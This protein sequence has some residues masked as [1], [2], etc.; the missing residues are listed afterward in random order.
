[1]LEWTP[2]PHIIYWVPVRSN[3]RCV[4]SISWW[5]QCT[6][7]GQTLELDFDVSLLLD[8]TS[9]TTT[10]LLIWK[11][12]WGNPP[13]SLTIVLH[14]LQSCIAKLSTGYSLSVTRASAWV[15]LWEP[16]FKLCQFIC[17]GQHDMAGLKVTLSNMHNLWQQ[18]TWENGLSQYNNIIR[19]W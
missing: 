19:L 13:A 8:L 18:R 2:G 3:S 10:M 14:W 17:Q 16:S 1:M 11:R 4:V 9:R 6:S 7:T 5:D 12:Q 15:F